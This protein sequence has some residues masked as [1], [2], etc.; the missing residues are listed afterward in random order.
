MQKPDDLN[1]WASKLDVD[2]VGGWSTNDSLQGKEKKFVYDV[3]KKLRST[4]V[5]PA[6]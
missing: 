3:A 2:Q 1:K 4:F 6:T 5:T